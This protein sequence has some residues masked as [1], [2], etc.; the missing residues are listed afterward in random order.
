VDGER[1]WFV[2]GGGTSTSGAWPSSCDSE[3]P[4]PFESEGSGSLIICNW[5]VLYESQIAHFN[6]S[7]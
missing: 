5:A 1:N 3:I 7:Q 2:A 4:G 6:P